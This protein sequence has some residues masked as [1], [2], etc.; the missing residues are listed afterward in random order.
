M[1]FDSKQ[2]YSGMSPWQQ[3]TSQLRSLELEHRRIK[4]IILQNKANS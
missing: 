3:I 1:R 2:E 4:I